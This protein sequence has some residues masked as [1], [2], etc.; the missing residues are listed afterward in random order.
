MI[1][2]G[3]G[4]FRGVIAEDF[5]QDN[6]SAIATAL[7]RVI[8]KKGSSRAVVVGYDR[9]FLSDR[10]CEWVANTL[11][12]NGIKVLKFT[13]PMPSPAVMYAVKSLGLD[14][15]VMITASHNPYYFNGVKIFMHGGM[16]ADVTLTKEIESEINLPNKDFV[17]YDLKAGEIQE[18]D[19]FNDYINNVQ[20]FLSPEIRRSNVRILYD[21]LFGVGAECLSALARKNGFSHFKVLN[22][23]HDAFFG[24]LAPNPTKESMQHLIS[25]LKEDGYDFAMAT[26]S[27]ADRLGILD[28][29]GNYVN[30]NDILGALYYY[31]TVY[32]GQKG[33]VVKNCATS[34]LID[35]LAKKFGQKCHEVDVGFKNVSHAMDEHD[36]LIGGE[37][38]GGLTVRGYVRGKDSVFSAMLFA[39]MVIR[40]KKPVSEIIRLVREFAE[41]DMHFIEADVTVNSLDN[42]VRVLNEKVPSVSAE[43][44]NIRRFGRNYK[45]ELNDGWALLRL[46]GTE[47]AVRIFVETSSVNKSERLIYEL[48]ASLKKL[49]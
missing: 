26:D 47:P 15:G 42:A 36:A 35:K 33:D 32:R 31:L 11:S 21:N 44:K 23:E 6:V 39:E 2:F 24:F 48:T 28:E 1:Q 22:V 4:G 45:Y 38:S 43:I 46:S 37:S 20:S 25:E 13:R 7:A 12:R 41:Y 14:Y 17:P 34:V 19:N 27:D 9:R 18:Y 3:T 16:D 10:A 8:H 30:S 5:T 49:I 40:M 29:N